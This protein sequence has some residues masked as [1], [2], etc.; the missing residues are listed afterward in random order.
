MRLSVPRPATSP[1]NP[2]PADEDLVEQ[3]RPGY[4]IPSQDPR[5]AAQFPL[6]PEEARREANS[7]LVGGGA[8]V[9]A[10]AGAAIGVALAGPVGIVA[11][12]ALG[13]IAGALGGEVAG[14]RVKLEVGAAPTR[15]RTFASIE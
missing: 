11:G 14:T 13:G 4:G 2:A 3:A 12:V 15:P 10:A 6:A 7:V 9:G 5:P 8:I 1:S